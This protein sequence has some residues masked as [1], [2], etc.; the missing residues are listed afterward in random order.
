[1]KL[2]QLRHVFRVVACAHPTWPPTSSLSSFPKYLSVDLAE[3]ETQSCK[4]VS[5]FSLHLFPACS[6]HLPVHPLLTWMF[7]HNV[8]H[9]EFD[10][11]LSNTWGQTIAIPRQTVFIYEQEP[12]WLY[13][14]A[15]YS[16]GQ[17][18]WSRCWESCEEDIIC[19]VL[20]GSVQV[21]KI[22]K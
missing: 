22:V 14:W 21:F 13:R 5:T 16:K 19:F 18:V 3:L 17:P 7:L 6:S 1:M 10:L 15:W 20:C 2:L 4:T 8:H 11:P 9:L 12:L